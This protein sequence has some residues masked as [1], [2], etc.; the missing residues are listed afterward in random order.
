[1]ECLLTAAQ[2]YRSTRDAVSYSIVR[3]DLTLISMYNRGA[4]NSGVTYHCSGHTPS[5]YRHRRPHFIPAHRVFG[6][7]ARRCLCGRHRQLYSPVDRRSSSTCG[8][9]CWNLAFPALPRALRR[10]QSGH[11]S[12][13]YDTGAGHRGTDRAPEATR[14]LGRAWLVRTNPHLECAS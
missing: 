3:Y 13:V 6:H 2:N 5:F 11:R 1:M 10:L 14:R 9:S 7:K 8:T 4:Q 12:S